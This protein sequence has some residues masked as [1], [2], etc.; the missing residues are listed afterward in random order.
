MVKIVCCGSD[1]ALKKQGEELFSNIKKYLNENNDMF[2]PDLDILRG[3]SKI[4]KI[5][6]MDENKSILEESDLKGSILKLI[7][8]QKS[9]P[10]LLAVE[11]FNLAFGELLS[12]VSNNKPDEII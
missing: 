11:D 6:L 4:L 12:N 8:E 3:K 7:W 9:K 5:Y 10:D 2:K 1:L